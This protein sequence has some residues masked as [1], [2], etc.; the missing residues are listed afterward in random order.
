MCYMNVIMRIKVMFGKKNTW[1]S[2]RR[3]NCTLTEI[4]NSSD[5]E[6]DMKS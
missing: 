2:K 6:I 3:V 5:F 4:E 1:T